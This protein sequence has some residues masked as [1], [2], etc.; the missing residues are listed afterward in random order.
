MRRES[1]VME[2]SRSLR[3]RPPI[4]CY[5]PARCLL[6][7]FLLLGSESTGLAALGNTVRV[8]L[9]GQTITA[10]HVFTPKIK[11]E[12]ESIEV[13]KLICEL[14][15]AYP[16]ATEMN[17]RLNLDVAGAEDRYGSSEDG[18]VEL[19]Q[20]KID[21][22]PQ[23]RKCSGFHELLYGDFFWLP[24]RLQRDLDQLKRKAEN[25]R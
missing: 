25:S 16:S 6:V 5:Q 14:A 22:L 12:D 24:S 10:T 20:L 17:L 2:Q 18:P 11:I 19:D 4:W 3:R 23:I 13:T 15:K 7:V 1:I 9:Q 21:N 8:V